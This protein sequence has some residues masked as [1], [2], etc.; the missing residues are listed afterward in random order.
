MISDLI[1][2]FPQVDFSEV[3]KDEVWPRKEG[4]YAYLYESLLERGRVA[5][6]W[7]EARPEKAIAVVSHDGFLRVGI[8]GRKFGN[9]HF[10]I[11]EFDEGLRGRGAGV[12]RM[13]EYGE[14]WRGIRDVSEGPVSMA[15]QRF[16]VYACGRAVS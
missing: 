2:L 9:A 12:G 5:R 10:R 4:L 13:G 11:F 1:P 6:K 14:K 3:E 15:A 16:Q 8:C 7:L